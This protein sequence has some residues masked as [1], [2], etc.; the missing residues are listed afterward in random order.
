MYIKIIN[1][2]KNVYKYE[3]KVAMLTMELSNS[4]KNSQSDLK[5]MNELLEE[6]VRFLTF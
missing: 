4:S 6:K 1:I 2:F 3:E 5:N